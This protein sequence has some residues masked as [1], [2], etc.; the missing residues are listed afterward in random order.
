[1]AK[2][3]SRWRQR[4]GQGSRPATALPLL[5]LGA[6]ALFALGTGQRLGIASAVLGDQHLRRGAVE[7]RRGV[8]RAC[9]HRLS[10]AS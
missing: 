2:S 7:P 6:A 4:A 1:M 3:R 10:R 5:G 8:A 9:G